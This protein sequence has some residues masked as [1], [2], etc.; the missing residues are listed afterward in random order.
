A[1]AAGAAAVAERAP[2]S[3]TLEFRDGRTW[4]GPFTLAPAPRLF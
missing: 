2:V 3:L 1:A 4:L